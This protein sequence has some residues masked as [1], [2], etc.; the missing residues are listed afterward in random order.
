VVEGKS[1]G[2]P[3]GGCGEG[4]RLAIR[5]F[6]QEQRMARPTRH[7]RES[8]PRRPWRTDHVW[9]RLD[10]QAA[11][12]R[13]DRTWPTYVGQHRVFAP[14]RSP[15]RRWAAILAATGHNRRR[16]S[17]ILAGREARKVLGLWRTRAPMGARR[18]EVF[19]PT[20]GAGSSRHPP[21]TSPPTAALGRFSRRLRLPAVSP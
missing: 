19:R 1:M 18:D 21:G 5:S 12:F 17:L 13:Q 7:G 6:T 8:G 9:R 20:C 10:L 14:R 2:Y 11:S 4:G 3:G 16:R 15:S